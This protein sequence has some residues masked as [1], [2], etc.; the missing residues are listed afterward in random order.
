MHC[1]LFVATIKPREG[2]N[3]GNNNNSSSARIAPS[4][5]SALLLV[6]FSLSV[7]MCVWER[8]RAKLL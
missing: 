6:V 2:H 3:L 5:S 8:A 1:Y 4:S 7:C